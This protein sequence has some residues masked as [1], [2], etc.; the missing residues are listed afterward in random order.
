[1][2]GN[3]IN[4]FRP[5]LR[6]RQIKRRQCLVS[7]LAH[8]ALE[9]HLARSRQL[10]SIRARIPFLKELRKIRLGDPD[11]HSISLSA[12]LPLDSAQ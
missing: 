2:L 8:T 9:V 11:A 7:R 12:A 4:G 3:L 6:F 5:L 1:M 10:V